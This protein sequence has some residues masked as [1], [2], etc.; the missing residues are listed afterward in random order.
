MPRKIRLP[1]GEWIEFPSPSHF[2]P[3]LVRV[4]RKPDS[5][6]SAE[7][8]RRV[9]HDE[10]TQPYLFETGTE[11]RLHFTWNCTQ[12]VMRLDEPNALV[13]GYTRKMMAFLLLNPAPRKILMLGLG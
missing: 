7:L 13:A 9:S 2:E 12:S 10:M 11:R 1:P 8:Q 4:L 5:P 6:D 3:G